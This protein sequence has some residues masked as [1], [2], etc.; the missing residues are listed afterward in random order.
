MSQGEWP[1][2][3]IRPGSSKY[4]CSSGDSLCSAQTAATMCKMAHIFVITA[5]H[6]CKLLAVS[7]TSKR[8]PLHP[9]LLHPKPVADLQSLRTPTSSR[10]SKSSYS[11]NS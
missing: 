3:H 8:H 10:L 11:L 6:R 9:C 7:H 2:A 5:A 4:P 1:L